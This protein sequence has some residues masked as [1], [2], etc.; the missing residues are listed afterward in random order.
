[1]G[2]GEAAALPF[3][4]RHPENH[5]SRD[6]A[7]IDPPGHGGVTAVPPFEDGAQA[8]QRQD[9]EDDLVGK[10]EAAG[11]QDVPDDEIAAEGEDRH[12]LVYLPDHLL[13]RPHVADDQTGKP[14]AADHGV[15]HHVQDEACCAER[16]HDLQRP[17]HHQ[18]GGPLPVPPPC[19]EASA[20]GSSASISSIVTVTPS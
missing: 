3:R 13:H 17:V 4:A 15:L 8:G 7:A 14:D 20:A 19:A 10:G 9:D 11:P 18:P 6:E 16:E 1:M 12:V 5:L 2:K